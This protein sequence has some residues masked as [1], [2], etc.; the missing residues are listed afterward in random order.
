MANF[1]TLV[2]WIETNPGKVILSV[3]ALWVLFTYGQSF[4]D[5]FIT[6]LQ[7]SNR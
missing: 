2:R 7:A 3:L 5:G 6:G 4:A 1:Q